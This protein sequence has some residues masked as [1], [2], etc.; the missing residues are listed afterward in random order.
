MLNV[1]VSLSVYLLQCHFTFETNVPQQSRL[2]IRFVI[3]GT[4]KQYCIYWRKVAL[5]SQKAIFQYHFW[6]SFYANPTI[7][8]H[9]TFG[10]I[11]SCPRNVTTNLFLTLFVLLL[12]YVFLLYLWHTIPQGYKYTCLNKGT[13]HT[14]SVLMYCIVTNLIVAMIVC[15]FPSATRCSLLLDFIVV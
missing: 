13:I 4:L 9:Y 15:L 1:S 11:C 14:H 10:T 3:P 5:K 7:Y 8:W 2:Q 6:F 12:N